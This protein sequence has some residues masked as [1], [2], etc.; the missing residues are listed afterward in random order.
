MMDKYITSSY[1]IIMVCPQNT[2]MQI[3]II[4]TITINL[5]IKNK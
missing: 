4:T 3:I 2:I 5:K 1:I